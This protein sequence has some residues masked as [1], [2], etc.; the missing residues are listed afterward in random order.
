MECVDDLE[1]D[2]GKRCYVGN[3]RQEKGSLESL[4]S[5]K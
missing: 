4:N 1:G 2:E 3:N 5:Q